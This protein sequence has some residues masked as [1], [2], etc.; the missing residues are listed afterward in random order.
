MVE[1][2]PILF[3]TEMVRA[4]LDGRKTQT[5]RVIKPQPLEWATRFEKAP[6]RDSAFIIGK[7]GDWLQMTEDAYSIRRLG[8]C[9]YGIT[10]DLLYVRETW[11]MIGRPYIPQNVV[12]RADD[13]ANH[14]GAKWKPSIHMPKKFARIWLEVKAV[15]VERLQDITEEDARDEG[16]VFDDEPCDHPRHGCKEIGCAGTG[17]RLGFAN[18]W[19]KTYAKRGY[20]WDTNPW[21]WVIEFERIER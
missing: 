1:E 5:R 9:P 2:H 13:T 4:I 14:P 16:A 7:E 10:G 15:R 18:L 3:S 19:H 6:F 12:Y 8:K 21:V 17:Y 20:G 11:K